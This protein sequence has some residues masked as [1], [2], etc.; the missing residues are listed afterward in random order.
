LTRAPSPAAGYEQILLAYDGS[1]NAQSALSRAA[2]LAETCRA[3]LTIVVVV[4]PSAYEE[5]VKSGN[6]VLGKAV[7][8]ARRTVGD[9]TGVLRDG[10]AADEILAAAEEQRADLVVIGRRGLSAV[11]RLLMG[12]TSSAVVAHSKCDVL[13]VK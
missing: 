6:E 5:T 13:V 2:S 1:K 9:V 10:Q 3:R 11:E 8:K 4:P 7:A 12:G